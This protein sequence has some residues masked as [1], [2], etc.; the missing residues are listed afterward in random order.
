M[1]IFI[2]K[3]PSSSPHSAADG[4]G[5]QDQDQE[6]SLHQPGRGRGGGGGGLGPGADQR[7]LQ[8]GGALGEQSL[9]AVDTDLLDQ[10]HLEAVGELVLAGQR[11]GDVAVSP[12]HRHPHRLHVVTGGRGGF[13]ILTL[14]HNIR[15]RCQLIPS[16]CQKHPLILAVYYY[17]SRHYFKD[18]C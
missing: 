16:P 18:L 13:S 1:S 4:E 7:H 17:F 8:H 2:T 15:R 9:D 14:I 5:V 6:G 10:L 12:G 11:Q 3:F